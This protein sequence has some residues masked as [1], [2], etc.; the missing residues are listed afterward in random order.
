MIAQVAIWCRKPNTHA[1]YTVQIA[2]GRCRLAEFATQPGQVHVNG[3][4]TSAVRLTPHVRQQ[5]AFGA[6]LPG[7]LGQS[8]QEVELL[9][10]QVNRQLVE[11]DLACQRVD[12]RSEE[13]T[14][15]RQ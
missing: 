9:A 4:V 2:R 14:A 15:A 3:S 13:Q 10:R 11:A 5:L 7:P 6:H 1:A 8:Q 12:R